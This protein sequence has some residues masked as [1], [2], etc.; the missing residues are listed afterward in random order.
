MRWRDYGEWDRWI[1]AGN[2]ILHAPQVGDGH[3]WHYASVVVGIVYVFVTNNARRLA[4][5]SRGRKL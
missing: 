5:T 1:W 2:V 3:W 4:S